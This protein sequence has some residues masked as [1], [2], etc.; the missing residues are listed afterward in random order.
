MIVISVEDYYF[1]NFYGVSKII[2]VLVNIHSI[3]SGRVVETDKEIDK[4]AERKSCGRTFSKHPIRRTTKSVFEFTKLSSKLW[5]NGPIWLFKGVY[6]ELCSRRPN[7]SMIFGQRLRVWRRLRY[8]REDLKTP[9]RG[10]VAT[11]FSNNQR[12]CF[13]LWAALLKTASH[14]T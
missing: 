7:S 11:F 2:L 8:R 13:F 3:C 4:L 1:V 10:S 12:K 9:R 6:G 5:L 14:N